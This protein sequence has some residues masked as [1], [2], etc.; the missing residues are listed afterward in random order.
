MAVLTLKAFATLREIVI[1]R[2]RA[3]GYLHSADCG[4]SVRERES[5]LMIWEGEGGLIP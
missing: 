3:Q 5:Q 1:Q 2:M 4:I